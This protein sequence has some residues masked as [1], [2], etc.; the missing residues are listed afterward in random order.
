MSAVALAV[1][2]YL[3]FKKPEQVSLVDTRTGA[4]VKVAEALA[5]EDGPRATVLAYVNG[6]TLNE[7]YAFIVEKR[8][9]LEAKLVAAENKVKKE[10][11]S[12]QTE[13]ERLVQYAEKNPNLSA[14]E[15]GAIQNDI[16]RMENEIAQ[17]Q[18]REMSVIQKQRDALDEE[19]HKKVG[20]YLEQYSK[21][22][23]IDYVINYQQGLRYILYGSPAYDI[24]SEVL[25][26]L[27]AEYAKEKE[28][29]K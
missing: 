19:L 8:G 13:V 29:K 9:Q 20:L 7:H 14:S 3:F 26:G 5:G 27:N 11:Q 6:D 4:E 10:Y 12:R 21:Q 15:Q 2:G 16:M 18:E 22:K 23:G 17:I 28:S 25:V 24:T 1:A